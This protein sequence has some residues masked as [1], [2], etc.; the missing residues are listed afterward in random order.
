MKK[1]LIYIIIAIIVILLIVVFAMQGNKNVPAPE[2]LVPPM[3]EDIVPSPTEINEPVLEEE[4]PAEIPE[5]TETTAE[6][7][8]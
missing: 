6:P 4:I 2:D 3:P 1:N 5:T 7:K 8:L